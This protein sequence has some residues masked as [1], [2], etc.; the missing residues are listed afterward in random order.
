MARQGLFLKWRPLVRDSAKARVRQGAFS[1][2]TRK[3]A[4]SLVLAWK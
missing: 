4:S 3:A 2:A 1:R